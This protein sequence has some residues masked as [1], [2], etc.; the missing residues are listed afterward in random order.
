MLRLMRIAIV[1]DIHG[2]RTAL[3]AVAADVR[4][5]SPDLILHGG[6]LADGGPDPSGVVDRI[7]E[8]GWPGVLGNTDEA[9]TRPQSLEEFARQS[10]A[11][12]SLWPAIREMT[13]W[14]RE[15]LGDDRVAWMSSLP[16]VHRGEGFSLVHASPADPWRTA[17]DA[18]FEVL[19]AP[20]VVHGH[21]HRSFIRDAGRFVLVN[22]GSV[23][24][25]Y[26]GDPRASYVL[27]DRGKPS[28]R[29]VVY[30][31]ERE[32]AALSVCGMPHAGWMIRTLRTAAAQMP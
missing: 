15:R 14:T 17:A 4:S 31:V 9:H 32:I 8:F 23:S 16:L 18:A 27:I 10:A 28:I 19:G 3:E 6:D 20:V 11:P 2:N 5:L 25:S 13:V 1:S 26:D 7:R 22:A 30:D 24:L 29:R 12:P 21:T